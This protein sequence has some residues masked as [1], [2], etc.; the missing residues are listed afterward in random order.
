MKNPYQST[1]TVITQCL[2]FVCHVK[3]KVAVGAYRLF[4]YAWRDYG[5]GIVKEPGKFRVIHKAFVG[6]IGIC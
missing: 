2:C 1:V 3:G 5:N 6:K 4:R